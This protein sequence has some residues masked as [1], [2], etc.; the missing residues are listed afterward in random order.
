MSD[1]CAVDGFSSCPPLEP[2][3]TIIRGRNH[4][5]NEGLVKRAGNEQNFD[6]LKPARRLHPCCRRARAEKYMCTFVG[7]SSF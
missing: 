7:R 6:D 3:Y 5:S 1:L 4:E 2:V